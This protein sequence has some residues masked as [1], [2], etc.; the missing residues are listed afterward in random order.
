[1]TATI[2]SLK[3][4][5]RKALARW[6]AES[7]GVDCGA[8]MLCAINP[9]ASQARRDFNAAMDELAKLDPACPDFRL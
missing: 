9:R 8:E 6:R 1:M 4:K 7:A 3:K 5:A 2:G